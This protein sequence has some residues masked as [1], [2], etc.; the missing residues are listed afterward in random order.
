M[1]ST[2]DTYS[3]YVERL[4]QKDPSVL[5]GSLCWYTVPEAIRV[6]HTEVTAALAAVGLD[7]HVPMAPADDDVFRQ[8]CSSHQR[9]KVAT[10]D[11]EIF[12]NYLIRDVVR[13]G[14]RVVKQIVVEKVDRRGEKLAHKASVNLEFVVATSQ[15][16]VRSLITPPNKQAMR[17]ADLIKRDFK[18][19]RGT[20]NAYGIRET[21][22]RVIAGTGAVIVRPSGGVYFVPETR[23]VTVEALAGF[24]AD[25][26]GVTFH[27]VPLINDADQS[28]MLREAIENETRETIQKTLDEIDALMS[29]PEISASKYQAMIDSMNSTISRTSEYSELLDDTLA[30]CEILTKSYAAKMRTLFAHVKP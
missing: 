16:N 3:K 1:A 12:E 6:P 11:A 19:Y 4:R 26:P 25:L 24:A 22:R 18:T 27:P 10:D 5:L 29:G 20:C 8:V 9:K 2:S 28:A 21:F 7:A 23:H 30:D 15:L 14:G 17:V 13:Q